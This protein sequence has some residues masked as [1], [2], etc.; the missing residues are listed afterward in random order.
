MVETRVRLSILWAFAT[1]NFIYAD[2]VTLYDKAGTF[3]FSP[4]FLL[5][6]A[7]LV[8]IPIAMVLLSRLLPY[9]SNRW[10]N[11]VAGA[12]MTIV[13]AATLFVGTPTPYY[14]FFSVLEI[15]ATAVVVWWAWSWRTPED[16]T[17]K[18][19]GPGPTQA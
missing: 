4:G 10:S 18:A 14:V 3:H 19:S 13:Q 6:A 12:A 5:G 9:R 17:A 2:V 16:R 1:L 8:E 7:V 11:I 15:V